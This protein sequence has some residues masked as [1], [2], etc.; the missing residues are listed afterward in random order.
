MET[1]GGGGYGDPLERDIQKIRTDLTEGMI[2]LEKARD[3]YGIVFCGQE[4]D[5]EETDRLQ[6]E[7]QKQRAQLRIAAWDGP[8]YAGARR[9]CYLGF[10]TIKKLGFSE[11]DL[12]ELVGLKG[13][14][15]RAWIYGRSDETEGEVFIGPTALQILGLACGDPIEVRRVQ[16]EDIT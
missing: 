4:I 9:M 3:R 16:I 13:G 5:R 2:T 8:E 11:G 7:I 6:E 10:K 1:S 15:L 12:V 14:P